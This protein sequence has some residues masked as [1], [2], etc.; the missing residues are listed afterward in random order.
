[1]NIR[2]R[3]LIILSVLAITACSSTQPNIQGIWK[4]AEKPAWIDLAFSG[5]IGS[6]Q[7]ARHDDNPEAEGQSILEQIV[8]DSRTPNRWFAKIYSAEEGEFV[9]AT[10]VLDEEGELI[11]RIDISS[12]DS[13]EV[14][15]LV[16]GPS[17]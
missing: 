10:L 16:R 1:M 13:G 3:A 17:N 2:R 11:V 9:D 12:E 15:R 6:A 4:H 8:S 5:R 7:I 14:L